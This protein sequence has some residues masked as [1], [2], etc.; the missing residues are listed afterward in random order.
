MSPFLVFVR[1]AQGSADLAGAELVPTDVWGQSAV[2]R[3]LAAEHPWTKRR[4]SRLLLDARNLGLSAAAMDSASSSGS[5]RSTPA[6]STESGRFERISADRAVRRERDRWTRRP[7]RGHARRFVSKGGQAGRRA[8]YGAYVLTSTV[9]PPWSL[10]RS[11][12]P[13]LSQV[14]LVTAIHPEPTPVVLVSVVV[15]VSTTLDAT[16]DVQFSQRMLVAMP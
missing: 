9:I 6:S 13:T 8:T 7:E 5:R 2:E 3:L 14:A 12:V 4:G 10:V 16:V 15:S 11:Q 1:L